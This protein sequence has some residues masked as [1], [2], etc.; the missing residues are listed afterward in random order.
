MQFSR[1]IYLKKHIKVY[2]FKKNTSLKKINPQIGCEIKEIR[3]ISELEKYKKDISP[4]NFAK[5]NIFLKHG[6]VGYFATKDDELL[7]MFFVTNLKKYYPF[8]YHK[9]LHELPTD[10]FSIFYAHTS[11]KY[12]GYKIFPHILSHILIREDNIT[13]VYACIDISNI[14]SQKTFE[15]V[16]FKFVYFLKYLKLFGIEIYAK[17]C[18]KN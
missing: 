5:F 2:L 13:P 4:I 18:Q 9:Y 6:C 15:R 17:K 1:Q 14:P 3:Y 11:G 8:S 16:G 12:M 10:A 7:S